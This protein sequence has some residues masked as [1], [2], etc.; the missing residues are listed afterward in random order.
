MTQQDQLGAISSG[1]TKWIGRVC[2][3]IT[4]AKTLLDFRNYMEYGKSICSLPCC[5]KYIVKNSENN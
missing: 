4:G 1:G 3:S 2:V 5:T